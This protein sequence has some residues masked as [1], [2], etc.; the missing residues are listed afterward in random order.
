[1]ELSGVASFVSRLSSEAGSVA[2]QMDQIW[3]GAEPEVY[4]AAEEALTRAF[5]AESM[6]DVVAASFRRRA[7]GRQ[8]E[9]AL[10]WLES[11]LWRHM[12]DLELAASTPEGL[13]QAQE[14]AASLDKARPSSARLEFVLRLEAAVGSAETLI[15][16]RAGIL[17]AMLERINLRISPGARW[18]AEEMEEAIE[19]ARSQLAGPVKDATVARMLFSYRSVSDSELRACVAHW[20]SKDG[21]WLSETARRSLLEG[22]KVGAARVRILRRSGQGDARRTAKSSA[23]SVPRR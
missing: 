5:A 2:S 13:R 8:L 11:P 17:K 1:M 20:E 6:H 4:Q 21:R 22:V 16:V 19:L 3:P 12:R 7:N 15:D 9:S 18:T 23:S 14:F 10:A